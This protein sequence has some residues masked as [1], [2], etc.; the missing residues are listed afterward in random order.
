ME[1]LFRTRP[2]V[3][4][5]EV[6]YIGGENDQPTYRNHP[7]HAEGIGGLAVIPADEIDRI[8]E[9]GAARGE[10]AALALVLRPGAVQRLGKAGGARRP[11]PRD[12]AEQRGARRLGV[13]L[14]AGFLA[15]RRHQHVNGDAVFGFRALCRRLPVVHPPVAL[16]EDGADV[17]YVPRRGGAGRQRKQGKDRNNFTKTRRNHRRCNRPKT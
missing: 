13:R 14:E 15:H 6:G 8:G 7:G 16:V 4:D 1:D 12:E 11:L 5:T 9:A 2:G 3:K 17:V 10:V